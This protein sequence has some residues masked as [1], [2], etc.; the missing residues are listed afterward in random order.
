VFTVKNTLIAPMH[1][2][3]LTQKQQNPHP[4]VVWVLYRTTG[5]ASIKGFDETFFFLCGRLVCKAG[6]LADKPVIGASGLSDVDSGKN[7]N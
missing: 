5:L 6:T 1:S 4:P 2:D 7:Y 3:A